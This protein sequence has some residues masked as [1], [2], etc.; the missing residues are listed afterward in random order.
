MVDGLRVARDDFTLPPSLTGGEPAAVAA[1][2]AEVRDALD[3]TGDLLLAEGVHQLVAGTPARA[4]AATRA[5]A[6]PRR[7]RTGST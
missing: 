3:A 7:R 1:A 2:I 5:A 6:G 4:A